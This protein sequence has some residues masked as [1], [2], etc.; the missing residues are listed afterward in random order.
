M[1]GKKI[2]VLGATGK[3]GYEIASQAIQRGHN[4]TVMVRDPARLT[5]PKDSCRIIVGSVTEDQSGLN[6]AIEGQDAVLSALGVGKS[7][8][9]HGLIEKSVPRILQGMDLHGV[10][11]LIFV[12]AYGVGATQ[13]DTPPLPRFL[14]KLFLRDVYDDKEAGDKILHASNV[15]WT[16]VY[17]T[18]LK[19]SPLTGRYRV[20]E[21]MALRG[22]PRISRADVAHFMLSQIDDPALVRKGVL[23]SS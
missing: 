15:D 19:D 10:R 2:L 1:S 18:T 14:M 23:I 8:K 22:L 3:T 5:L 21:R 12:S 4:V 13:A 9:P 20:G 6:D 17:P 7:F 11:R 16:L